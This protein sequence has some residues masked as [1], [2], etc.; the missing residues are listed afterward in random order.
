MEE[1]EVVVDA[2][3]IVSDYNGVLSGHTVL[4]MTDPPAILDWQIYFPAFYMN[5][6][7]SLFW[8]I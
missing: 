2:S 4:L 5:H 7:F 3:T 6:Y 8:V 1:Y